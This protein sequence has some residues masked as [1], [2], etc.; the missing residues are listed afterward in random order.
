MSYLKQVL[1]LFG[2]GTFL[3]I[4]SSVSALTADD[5]NGVWVNEKK[6]DRIDLHEYLEQPNPVLL[7][8]ESCHLIMKVISSNSNG[9][10]VGRYLVEEIKNP[11]QKP[12]AVLHPL[13]KTDSKTGVT[14]RDNVGLFAYYTQPNGSLK[15]VIISVI[16][17]NS[18]GELILSK[19]KKMQGIAYKFPQKLDRY[20]SWINV[21]D[22]T[23][24]G[25]VQT[26]FDEEWLQIYEQGQ[27]A[28]MQK[29]DN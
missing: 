20:Q 12:P 25:N 22:L 19:T 24:Q 4:S 11:S 14:S 10:G 3:F 7:D 16:N 9:S 28:I 1:Y 17:Q 18:F 27:D 15:I 6:G 13:Q 23:K 5:I 21:A 29:L 26:N 2:V 8:E